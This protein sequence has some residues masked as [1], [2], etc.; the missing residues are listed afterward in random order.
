LS[1][2]ELHNKKRSASVN[3]LELPSCIFMTPQ[4]DP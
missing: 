1:G 2:L 4:I 3:C